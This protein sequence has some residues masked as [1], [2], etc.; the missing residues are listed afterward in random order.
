MSGSAMSSTMTSMARSAR[1][2][3]IDVH[4]A[5]KSV[6][7]STTGVISSKRRPFLVTYAV[8]AAN[9]DASTRVTA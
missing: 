8:P 1:F 5:P 7:F 3:A 4:V 9:R 6:V 2:P